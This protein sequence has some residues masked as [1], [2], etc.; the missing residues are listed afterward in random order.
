MTITVPILWPVVPGKNRISPHTFQKTLYLQKEYRYLTWH[1]C[2]AYCHSRGFDPIWQMIATLTNKGVIHYFN[3]ADALY[4]LFNNGILEIKDVTV[5]D[6]YT[7]YRSEVR[8]EWDLDPEHVL[9]LFYENEGKKA[10]KTEVNL[11]L[12][13]RNTFGVQTNNRRNTDSTVINRSFHAK[14]V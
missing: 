6:N 5:A 10:L 8:S 7:E 3:G 1:K 14:P 4:T 2:I 12:E 9:L 11:F 13:C